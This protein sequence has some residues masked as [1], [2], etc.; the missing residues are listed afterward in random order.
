MGRGTKMLATLNKPV[1]T[2]QLTADQKKQNQD[3]HKEK[4]AAFVGDPNLDE[5][6][7]LVPNKVNKL[8]QELL[9]VEEKPKSKKSGKGKKVKSKKAKSKK[10]K[11]KK[12][13]RRKRLY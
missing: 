3:A 7:D 11:G 6:S 9:A 12:S 4:F 5:E 8:A 2:G 10:T 13:F 1:N